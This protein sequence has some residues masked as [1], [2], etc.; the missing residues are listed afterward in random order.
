M[1]LGPD[2][3]IIV[4]QPDGMVKLWAQDTPEIIA[5]L[6]A[7]EELSTCECAHDQCPSEEMPDWREQL[8]DGTW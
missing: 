5:C 1:L 2:D 3:V 6:D 8:R 4:I 7:V